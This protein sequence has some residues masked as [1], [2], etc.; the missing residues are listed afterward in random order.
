MSDGASE[1]YRSARE[2]EAR[3]KSIDH[4]FGMIIARVTGVK[5]NAKDFR[6]AFDAFDAHRYADNIA[7]HR[8]AK[9]RGK[10]WEKFLSLL[11]DA[12]G[13]RTDTQV[14][15]GWAEILSLA[16]RF[17]SQDVT[18]GLH[19]VSV[20]K[21]CHIVLYVPN[22]TGFY[23]RVPPTLYGDLAAALDAIASDPFA[24]RGPYAQVIEDSERAVVGLTAGAGRSEE[25]REEERA[26]LRFLSVEKG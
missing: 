24:R 25:N 23:G 2:H 7:S 16:M 12:S 6:G 19:A 8:I 17:A 4:F 11:D 9:E 15:T 5:T 10:R 14:V 21:S 22:G 18:E 1:G 13:K 20:F 3:Q 26:K